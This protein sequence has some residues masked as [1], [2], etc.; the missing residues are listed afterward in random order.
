[1]DGSLS[2]CDP[3]AERESPV[4]AHTPPMSNRILVSDD[5]PDIRDFISF[6]LRRAGHDVTAVGDGSDAL[7]CAS[8]EDFDLAIL[9]HHMPG[10]TGLEIVSRL[11]EARPGLRVLLMS[12][13][14]DVGK[15]HPHFLPKPF[16][17]SELT[18]AVARL[19]ELPP[20]A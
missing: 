20:S 2:C 13:D 19:L 17:R 7:S 15:Q 9:D 18:T 16:N 3:P 4:R 12:G 1:M 10:M 14:Q 11:R 8:D 6:V 5:E